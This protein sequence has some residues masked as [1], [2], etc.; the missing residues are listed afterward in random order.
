MNCIRQIRHDEIATFA[1]FAHEVFW[2]SFIDQNSPEAMA[3][4]CDQAFCNEQLAQEFSTPYSL[5]FYIEEQG[6]IAGYMKLNLNDAQTE[7]LLDNA[8]EVEHLYVA[9]QYQGTGLG[10]ALLQ[11]A[12]NHAQENG[13]SWLWLGVWEHNA[14]SIAFYQRQGLTFFGEHPFHFGNEKQTDLLMK[15]PVVKQ[16]CLK[17]TG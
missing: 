13:L 6:E 4:Y 3:A 10:K 8:L 7:S 5:F 11:Y 1:T 12:L 16:E 15:M 2:Q 14:S 9:P 17:A